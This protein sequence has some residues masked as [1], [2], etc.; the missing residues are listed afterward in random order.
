MRGVVAVGASAGGVE[1]LVRFAEGLPVNLPYA[2][3]VTLHIPPSGP[4]VLAQILSRH[5][6][7]PVVS[8]T[9][10]ATV[11]PGTIYCA[12][13]NR[14][15]LLV[16]NRIELSQGPTENRHRPAINA[17]FR[18]VAISC[19][20]RAV[21]VLLSGALDDGVLGLAAIR[22]NGGITI[23]QKPS[24]ALFSSMPLSAIEAG[25]ADREATAPHIGKLL[26]ELAD[27]DMAE[28]TAQPDRMLELENRIAM[29]GPFAI[30]FGMD[31]LGSPSG[32]T[33]P[34]CNGSLVE[35]SEHNYRCNLGH[36][37]TA[38]SLLRARDDEVESAMWVALRSL[39][40]KA[41]LSRKMANTVR[42]RLLR[43]RYSGVAD[44][45]E[46][47]MTVLSDRLSMAYPDGA[48]QH[49]E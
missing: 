37:W 7:M 20:R 36:A 48:G 32:Y 22:A 25:V 30:P 15:L 2:V 26:A 40:E 13:P 42:L 24:D 44:E 5:T 33:C 12:V 10:G 28:E 46:H 45:A 6:T 49:D 1:S 17:L 43:D 14:H 27:R 39:Q 21:G 23:V 19:G 47:A 18:S 3:M 35:V 8:A 4:S 29:G 16:G 38:E 31:S 9:D 41:N 34:D 11:E